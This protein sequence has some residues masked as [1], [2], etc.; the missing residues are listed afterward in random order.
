MQM[1]QNGAV[2]SSKFRIRSQFQNYI[3]QLNNISLFPLSSH[4]LCGNIHFSCS[5]S[6]YRYAVTH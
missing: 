2:I 4:R 3:W 6:E 1:R 5:K